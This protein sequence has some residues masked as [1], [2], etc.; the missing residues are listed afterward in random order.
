VTGGDTCADLCIQLKNKFFSK[1]ITACE[2]W[3][4]QYDPES[5][6]QILQWIQPTS[7][8]P[9]K[10]R[11]SKSQMKTMLRNFLYIK[12]TVHSEFIPQGRTINQAYYVEI[13]MRLHE[14]ELWP[15]DWILHHDNAP[16]HKTLS[17]KQF[18]AQKSITE[19]EH[20][21]CSP[22]LVPN[23]FWLLPKIKFALKGLIF[24]DAEDIQINVTA[25][26]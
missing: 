21:P 13:L 18:P 11:M 8:R 15:N 3:F 16:V 26:L 25:A 1:I 19:M 2:T 5:K 6:R 12:A 17:V 23:D 4:F 9:N 7:P 22:D 24:Q 20:P 14:A 10:A